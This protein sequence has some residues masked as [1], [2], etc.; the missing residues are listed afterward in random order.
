MKKNKK[1]KYLQYLEYINYIEKFIFDR[2]KT[3]IEYNTEN[4]QYLTKK[5]IIYINHFL[6]LEYRFYSL[7]HEIGHVILSK[8]KKIYGDNFPICCYQKFSRTKKA[9]LDILREEMYA[10]D[11]GRILV[12]GIFNTKLNY[13][14]FNYMYIC[15]DSY[16]NFVIEGKCLGR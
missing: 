2:Y 15:L 5:N 12:E 13:K 9:R 6:S 4:C 3:K 16:V 14:F 1:N 10:W 7:I 8:S 11:V